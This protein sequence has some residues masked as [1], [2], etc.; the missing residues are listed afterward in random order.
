[1]KSLLTLTA[2]VFILSNF[3]YQI[4]A[5]ATLNTNDPGAIRKRLD[6]KYLQIMDL[7]KDDWRFMVVRGVEFP[8]GNDLCQP[9]FAI[10]DWQPK[11][12]GA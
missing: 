7:F 1:M 6:K 3:G 10:R 2:S 9:I 11:Q 12:F 4:S 5:L 8:R